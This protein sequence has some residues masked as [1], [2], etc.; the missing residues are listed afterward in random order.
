MQAARV[1]AQEFRRGFLP[2]CRH[3]HQSELQPRRRQALQITAKRSG[4]AARSSVQLRPRKYPDAMNEANEG[5]VTYCPDPVAREGY[6][7]WSRPDICSATNR[8]RA[9]PCR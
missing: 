7:E 6:S 1:I 5:V 4:L 2:G 9:A 3:A 8:E